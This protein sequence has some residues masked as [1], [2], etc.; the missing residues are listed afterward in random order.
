MNPDFLNCPAR[1][2]E[3]QNIKNFERHSVAIMKNVLSVFIRNASGIFFT[4]LYLMVAD[5]S[6]SEVVLTPTKSLPQ[7]YS[8]S[9]ADQSAWRYQDLSSTPDAAQRKMNSEVQEYQFKLKNAENKNKFFLEIITALALAVVGLLVLLIYLLYRKLKLY[10][11]HLKERNFKLKY[12]TKRDPLTGL[13]NRRAFY[14]TMKRRRKS[15]NRRAGLESNALQALVILDVDQYKII[16]DTFGSDVGDIVLIEVSHRLVETMRENDRLFRWGEEEYLMHLHNV[17]RESLGAIVERALQAVGGTCV[18]VDLQRLNVTVSIGFIL[19]EQG[20]EHVA[21]LEKSL[22]IADAALYK[23]K[24][25]GRNQ[26]IG[27]HLA[28]MQNDDF[29]DISPLNLDD[30]IIKGKLTVSKISGPIQREAPMDE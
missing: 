2:Q 12:Q 21:R 24:I 18:E 19:L 16:N 30:L 29:N 23:A 6:A 25:G 13:P 22:R 10:D 17:T 27:A 20:E 3:I 5:G 11:V 15:S 8:A 4:S 28:I 7:P 9:Q 26:A 1:I 14:E